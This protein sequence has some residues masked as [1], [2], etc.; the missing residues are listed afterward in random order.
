MLDNF[1]PVSQ[2]TQH[3][4]YKNQSMLFRKIVT[5]CPENITKMVS[6]ACVQNAE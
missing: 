5:D 2:K 6:A 4:C 1:V 3:H